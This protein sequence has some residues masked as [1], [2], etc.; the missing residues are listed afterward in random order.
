M[1][2][3]PDDFALPSEVGVFCGFLGTIGMATGPITHLV[4]RCALTD[5]YLAEK[6]FTAEPFAWKPGHFE[7]AIPEGYVEAIRA[8]DP[9]LVT[10]PRERF[11]LTELVGQDPTRRHRAGAVD[12][13]GQ[14]RHDDDQ[15]P[16]ERP[17][18]DAQAGSTFGSNSPTVVPA[19]Y[20]WAFAQKARTA[21]THRPTAIRI[22][23]HARQRHRHCP[24]RGRGRPRRPGS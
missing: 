3:S 20:R 13:A 9:S 11:Y 16:P 17:V 18:L 8:N 15:Q 24:G 1:A 5:R 2:R 23:R 10:D 19:K 6:P 22:G 7:R 14:H 4:D 21:L 12:D